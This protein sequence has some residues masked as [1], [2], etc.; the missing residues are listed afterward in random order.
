MGGV[1]ASADRVYLSNRGL[2][3][4]RDSQSEINYVSNRG[5]REMA[6]KNNNMARRIYESEGAM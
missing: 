3:G 5:S 2:V 6:F 1:H 4:C